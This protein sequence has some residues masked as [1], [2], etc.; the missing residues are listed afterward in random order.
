MR[1]RL[2][3]A[4]DQVQASQ[5]LKERTLAYLERETHGY[6]RRAAGA[7]AWAVAAACCLVLAVTGGVLYFT[8]TAAISV[9]VNPSLELEVNR[10]DR[11]IS[12][13]GYQEDGQ[14]LADAVD[15]SHLSYT[16]ALE[17]LMESETITDCL[18]NG[19]LLSITVVGDGSQ[20]TAILAQAERWA[21]GSENVSCCAGDP[22]AVDQAH[23]AGLSFGK[24]QA[25]LELQAL[26]PSV[27]EEAAAG[28]TMREIRDRIDALTGDSA[29]EQWT[30]GSS[31]GSGTG[32]GETDS[33]H[34]GHGWGGRH[35]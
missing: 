5:E 11:V 21:S 12:V 19:E 22:E 28:M 20:R 1:E 18:A 25:F 3:E 7:A 13:K 17:R 32:G 29:G 34:H 31:C 8:P 2:R 26:D 10:F 35:E 16:E 33:G 15:L 30:S 23:A 27:T 24:Y 9:D 14:A 4:L 6:R